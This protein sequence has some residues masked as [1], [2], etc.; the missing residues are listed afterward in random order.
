M[1]SPLQVSFF[2]NWRNLEPSH[3]AHRIFFQV[4]SP[5]SCLPLDT[6]RDLYTFFKLWGPEL[7]AVFWA[8]PHQHWIQQDNNLFDWLVMLCLLHHRMGFALLVAKTHCS[9]SFYSA[10]AGQHPQILIC[11]AVL[12]PLFSQFILVPGVTQF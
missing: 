1:R 8:R 9:N 3:A 5:L 4:L 10:V 7:H 12:Q 11:R 2:L 6:L